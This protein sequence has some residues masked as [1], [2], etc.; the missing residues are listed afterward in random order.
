[1]KLCVKV[2]GSPRV[3]VLPSSSSSTWSEMSNKSNPV[4]LLP[5]HVCNIEERSCIHGGSG[6]VFNNTL[7]YILIKYFMFLIIHVVFVFLF[8][9]VGF[10][11]FV[12]FSTLF[13]VLFLLMVIVS[14]F[15]FVHNCTYHGH[16]VETQLH[17]INIVSFLDCLSVFLS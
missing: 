2:E 16:W 4:S 3:N 14:L 9:M 6:K 1:M 17:L 13:R 10:L 12:F 8:C 7:Y 11:L 15:V 5:H